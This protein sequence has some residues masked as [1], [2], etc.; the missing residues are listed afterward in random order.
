MWTGL[1]I[2]KTHSTLETVTDCIAR[3]MVC[4]MITAMRTASLWRRE[5]MIFHFDL[6]C[7]CDIHISRL[8]RTRH[9]AGDSDLPR[10]GVGLPVRFSLSTSLYFPL[11]PTLLCYL[12]PLPCLF[13]FHFPSL[14]LYPSDPARWPAAELSALWTQDGFRRGIGS[15]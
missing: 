15:E 3:L 9:K 4:I 13:L 5:L 1:N 8:R 7:D 6:K 10:E 2:W 14:P 11:F 12:F